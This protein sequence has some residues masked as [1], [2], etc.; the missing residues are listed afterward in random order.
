MKKAFLVIDINT[1][2][3][4]VSKLILLSVHTV[5]IQ[6]KYRKKIVPKNNTVVVNNTL[7][8]IFSI[9]AASNVKT[10]I[11]PNLFDRSVKNK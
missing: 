4:H 8:E 3:K 7:G 5:W 11:Q 9:I 6:R 1:V 2:A 10:K